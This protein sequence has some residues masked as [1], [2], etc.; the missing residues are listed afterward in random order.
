[1]AYDPS[2]RKI[3]LPAAEVKTED[4]K[5]IITRILLRSWSLDQVLTG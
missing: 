2:L 4:G 5:R 3:Y 1:M